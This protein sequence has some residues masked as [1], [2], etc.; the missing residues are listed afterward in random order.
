MSSASA[1]D[2]STSAADASDL[3]DARERAD[4]QMA[5]AQVAEQRNEYDKAIKAYNTALELDPDRWDA[6]HRLALIHGR[7]GN[8]ADAEML[9]QRIEQLDKANPAVLC[10]YGYS[11]YLQERWQEAE[12]KFSLALQLEPRNRR[13][14]NQLGMLLARTNRY[15]QSLNEFRQA[16]LSE[17]EARLN[18]A[19][20]MLMEGYV[21]EARQQL[22]IVRSQ[23]PQASV[24]DRLA[25]L[26]HWVQQASAY[27]QG[28]VSNNLRYPGTN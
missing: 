20:A 22:L 19:L 1:A 12:A 13:A 15:D 25:N 17:Q 3:L 18:L 27:R 8:S 28:L 26:E 2:A 7:M 5:F 21:D 9:Y 11:L 24:G 16:G 6:C 14:H 10:D 23:R 4:I